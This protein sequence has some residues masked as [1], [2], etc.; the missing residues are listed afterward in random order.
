MKVNLS[1]HSDQNFEVDAKDK[2]EAEQKAKD[3]G[4]NI[5]YLAAKDHWTFLATDIVVY[6][7]G[8]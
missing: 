4:W 5:A 1:L 6:V 2:K 7:E 8:R 3:I